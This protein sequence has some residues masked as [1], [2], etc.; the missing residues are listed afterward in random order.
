MRRWFT[1]WEAVVYYSRKWKYLIL[2]LGF[3]LI[4]VS[5]YFTIKLPIETD[6]GK[7][8]PKDTQSVKNLYDLEKKLG[9]IGFFAI[10]FETRNPD[11][12]KL[13]SISKK[14]KSHFLQNQFLKE[15][16]YDIYDK[17]PS[18]FFRNYALHFIE[19]SDLKKI[20]YRL[21]KKITF[22][23][24]R[25]NPFFVNIENDD[26][27]EFYIG[28]LLQK[29]RKRYTQSDYF[30]DKEQK[31]LAIFIKP[32]KTSTNITFNNNFYEHLKK[33]LTDFDNEPELKYYITGRYMLELRQ[34]K[35]ITQDIGKTTILT[36]M[37][38]FT[39]LILFF[40][41]M[42]A[43]I[44]IGLPLAMG[45]LTTFALAYLFIGRVNLISAFLT[46]ILMGLGI[47]YG[48]HLFSRY[49]EERTKGK[50]ISE[51]VTETMNSILS[52][53]GLGA[54]TTGMAFLTLAFSSFTAFSEFGIIAFL[55]IV[56]TLFS[57]SLFF[58]A[59]LFFTEKFSQ[60]HTS[61]IKVVSGN[62]S[63]SR[64]RFYLV[65]FL[66]L[67]GFLF[68]KQLNF[69]YNF[70]R[71]DARN[72]ETTK[73]NHALNTIVDQHG[74]PIIFVAK[75]K[76][77]LKN[78]SANIAQKNSKYAGYS[79]NILSLIPE[80][81]AQRK[82]LIRKINI[83]LK[84]ARLIVDEKEKP[85]EYKSIVNGIALSNNITVS[86][87]AIPDQLKKLLLGKDKDGTEL[88]FHY[89]YP[90]NLENA[91]RG[92]IDFVSDFRSLC[93]TPLKEQ[94]K[95]P[96][97]EQVHGISD[98]FILD[99]I[100]S[101]IL[102]DIRNGSIFIAI[103]VLLLIVL[104]SRSVQGFALIGFPLV[105]GMG[106]MFGILELM[107]TFSNSVL[108]KLNYINALSIPLLFGVG[109]DNGFH[110][111]R[112]Y[113]ENGMKAIYKVMNETG[114]AVLLSN[115]TTMIGFGSLTLSSHQGLASLGFFTA[116]GIFCIFISY[117]TLF[118]VLAEKLK[119]RNT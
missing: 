33:T 47:D 14:F 105:L 93:K 25:L 58:P 90:Q 102:K 54:L 41:S 91:K 70:S 20:A 92:I 12:E 76:K 67:L 88:Y 74:N 6:L 24:R 95:C 53:I 103:T 113:K 48:V 55:G 98:S 111:F 86:Q 22:E 66:G 2:I 15:N 71:L 114:N 117:F 64:L 13:I 7:L 79:Q 72:H 23:Q 29:Y 42:R 56:S 44:V 97:A 59:L 52:S 26:N 87:N 112:S 16:T 106:L 1:F 9:G 38:L 104:L 85:K 69:E 49:K 57:F 8:L 46:A 82:P 32:N 60:S 109:I 43:A 81:E 116:L 18:D 119:P 101:V 62:Y 35:S 110:L 83:M 65:V 100:L 63:V 21:E 40:R 50:G 10:I 108:F 77:L 36:L 45:L 73:A 115:L 75:E 99:D 34:N 37:L 96:P 94:Q 89:L 78:F 61:M 19:L 84:A 31:R 30:I 5:A 28:D 68:I 27:V 11:L 118:P 39:L 17:I 107:G 4:I 80:D 3:S 51:A